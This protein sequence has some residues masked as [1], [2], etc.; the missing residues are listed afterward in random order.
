LVAGLKA[1]EEV[2]TSKRARFH[3]IQINPGAVENSI[4]RFTPAVDN[5]TEFPLQLEYQ[6]ANAR[7]DARGTPGGPQ[8]IALNDERGSGLRRNSPILLCTFPRFLD[9]DPARR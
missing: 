1:L 7:D 3:Q 8:V 2:L 4:F 9:N 6:G 5:P